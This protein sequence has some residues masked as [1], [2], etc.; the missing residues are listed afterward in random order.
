MQAADAEFLARL[1]ALVA[2][3]QAESSRGGCG[4]KF[5][6][7]PDTLV[8]GRSTDSVLSITHF[9]HSDEQHSVGR[10]AMQDDGGV[11]GIVSRPSSR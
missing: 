3:V 9:M 8:F 5:E 10:A 1:S 2:Q 11:G 6:A 7:V 4:A